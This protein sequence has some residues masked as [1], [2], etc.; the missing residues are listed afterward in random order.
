M[1]IV[2]RKLV[3]VVARTLVVAHKLVVV[4]N[5]VVGN[6]VAGCIV[7][8]HIVVADNYLEVVDMP[9]ISFFVD[10]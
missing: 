3:V 8:E 1:L 10:F 6:L 7:V 2:L 5:F 4:G 9:S